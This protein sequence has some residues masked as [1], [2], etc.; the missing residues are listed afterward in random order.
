MPI[1]ERSWKSN[2][3]PKAQRNF[4]PGLSVLQICSSQLEVWKCK[5]PP[6]VSP[7]G[8][9]KQPNFNPLFLYCVSD[10]HISKCVFLLCY[11]CTSADSR[12]WFFRGWNPFAHVV[13]AVISH[14][15][16]YPNSRFPW[17]I[18]SSQFHLS[19]ILLS[20]FQIFPFSSSIT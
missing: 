3:M 16:F 13:A 5:P 15:T 6:A 12:T 20:T 11:Q 9:K 19:Q 7:M 2:G 8:K 17:N 1:R 18:S 10:L 14:G 4:V